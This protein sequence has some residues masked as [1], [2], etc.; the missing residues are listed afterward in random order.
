[1][2]AY[3]MYSNRETG[4]G[5]IPEDEPVTVARELAPSPR[6]LSLK[7]GGKSIAGMDAVYLRNRGE[8][9][10]WPS[11]LADTTSLVENNVRYRG[12]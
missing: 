6:V 12:K 10:P 1:M 11:F 2:Y 4:V 9:S 5:L 3:S 8:R 7:P